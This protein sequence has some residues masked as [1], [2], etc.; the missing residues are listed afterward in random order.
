MVDAA[1]LLRDDPGIR[2]VVIGRGPRLQEVKARAARDGL[3]NIRFEPHQD[4]AALG[5]SLGVADVHVSVLQPAFEGLVHPSKLYG[6]MAAGR[7]TLFIGDAEGETAGILAATGSGISVGTGDAAGVV[8]AI[9]SLRADPALRL[10]MGEAARRAFDER[11][12]M[13][14]A[15]RQWRALLEAL[16]AAPHHATFHR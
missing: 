5:Q 7:P 16:D 8:T 10:Q 6:I 2:F 4:R 3:A 12:A 1:V 11:Y 13:P 9:R 14:I 15:L